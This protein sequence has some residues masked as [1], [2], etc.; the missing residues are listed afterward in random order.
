MIGRVI[1]RSNGWK[2]LC[3]GS[4]TLRA[5]WMRLMGVAGR[6]SHKGI[7]K[8]GNQSLCRPMRLCF[9]GCFSH[10]HYWVRI[11]NRLYGIRKPRRKLTRLSSQNFHFNRSWSG[12]F[13]LLANS[14]RLVSRLWIYGVHCSRRRVVTSSEASTKRNWKGSNKAGADDKSLSKKKKDDCEGYQLLPSCLR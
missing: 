1:A 10:Q 9:F 13:A 4:V 3:P 11:A 6:E 5:G 8:E 2:I 14:K 7:R 12:H